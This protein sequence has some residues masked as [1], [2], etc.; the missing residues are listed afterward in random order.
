MNQFRRALSDTMARLERTDLVPRVWAR[1]WR[2]WGDEPDG[3]E[4]RLGWL[5]LPR[6]MHAHRAYITDL[7]HAVRAAGTEHVV[8]LGMGGSSLAP[9]VLARTFGPQPEHPHL[10][11]LDSTIPDAVRAVRGRIDPARSMFVVS[12]KSGTTA[13]PLAFLDYFWAE[14][15]AAGADP[16]PRF[17][18][19]TDPGSP[20]VDMARER[21]FSH[22]VENQ[23]DVGGRYAALSFVGLLP[24]AL[25][26][27]D[28]TQILARGGLMAEACGQ[29]VPGFEHPGVGLAAAMA[30]G[31]LSRRDKLTVFIS[32][33]IASFGLW[34]EQLVAESLGKDGRGV[35]PVIGE[36]LHAPEAYGSDRVFVHLRLDP[37]DLYD[38]QASDLLDRLSAEAHPVVRIE[39]ADLADVGAQFVLWEFA[40]ALAGALMG[41]QP[42]DQP[43]VEEAK[44]HAREA[45]A[46]YIERGSRPDVRSRGSLRELL[47]DAKDG[48]YLAIMAFVGEDPETDAALE[49]LRSAVTERHRIATTVGYGPR[50]LHSTGQLHKG[51]PDTCIGL[52]IVGHG[53]DLDV[54]GAG[55]SFGVLGDA[56]AAGDLEALSAKGR[57]VA[58]VRAT[59]PAARAIRKLIKEV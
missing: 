16:G 35:V 56:Q 31:G 30:A 7:C 21:G 9:E 40:T 34:L 33:G 1:D 53:D 39:V 48:D 42:F 46:R 47:E 11:V 15:A 8:V 38:E 20:L 51:G 44:V 58:R 10:V 57:R 55:Y 23:P 18:A 3:I 29:A 2:V 4:D 49:E 22:I 14:V 50:F 17:L 24:A 41:V 6:S 32:P 54:P 59:G 19:I 25:A 36:P 37:G 13:E 12:S 5:D 43:D 28:W 27:I 52:Q 26:G 45:L